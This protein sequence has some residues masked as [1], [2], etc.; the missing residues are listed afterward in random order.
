MCGQNNDIVNTKGF[1][2]RA[3]IG[4]TNNCVSSDKDIS[5]P[6]NEL[7]VTHQNS[8]VKDNGVKSYENKHVKV[9]D[10]DTSVRCDQ[11]IHNSNVSQRPSGVE[12]C[13]HVVTKDDS[14]VDYSNDTFTDEKNLNGDSQSNDI[15]P[16]GVRL[17]DIKSHLDDKFINN[18]LSKS[19]AKR[20]AANSHV[21]CEVFNQWKSQTDFDFG[22]IPL[23]DLIL[24][25]SNHIG[26]GFESPIDQ[27][28]VA[29]DFGV[30]NFLGARLPVKSQLNIPVWEDWLADYWDK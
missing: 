27:H 23:T 25:D 5:D 16:E 19:V 8:R 7:V 22:F 17:F 3:N 15:G 11:S 21:Q 13:D 1:V 24:P 4:A 20:V 26:P 10:M 14:S 2:C 30:P 12:H 9:N 18:F 29:K 6:V 28:Y